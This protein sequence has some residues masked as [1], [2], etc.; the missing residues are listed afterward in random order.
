M[1]T[2]EHALRQ[3]PC[4]RG[5]ADPAEPRG[6]LVIRR[7]GNPAEGKLTES[8][9]IAGLVGPTLTALAASELLNPSIW[10]NVPAAQTYLAGTLWL[11]AGLSIVHAHNRWT[12]G[13]RVLV[14]LIGWF[15]ILGGLF[16]MFAPEFAQR[17]VPNASALL[18]MQ[19]VLLAIGIYLTF[20]AYRPSDD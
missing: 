12:C 19:L 1:A 18:A 5:F 4:L 3:T 7:P 17:N 11:V 6:R 16:R 9:H 13:W 2:P 20:K 10:A 15:A 14:T 8:R